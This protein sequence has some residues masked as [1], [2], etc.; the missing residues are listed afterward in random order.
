M[1]E[2]EREHLCMWLNVAA[3]AVNYTFTVMAESWLEQ[4]RYTYI[5]IEALDNHPV[6]ED[7]KDELHRISARWPDLYGD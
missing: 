1:Y 7:I 4:R 3:A 5:A 6:T 2:K